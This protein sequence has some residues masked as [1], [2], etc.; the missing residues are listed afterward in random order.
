LTV[1]FRRIHQFT[2]YAVITPV[3]HAIADY[4]Q[5]TPNHYKELPQFYEAKRDRFCELLQESRFEFKPAAGTFFQVLDYSGITDEV[6]VAYARR[7]TKEIGVASIPISVFCDK[8]PTT[9][10]LRFC[11]AKDDATLEK[12]AASLCQL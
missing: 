8:T 2:C 1:E 4:M 6:D 9:R 11:F 5:K 12:A 3:Q 10:E 7:L